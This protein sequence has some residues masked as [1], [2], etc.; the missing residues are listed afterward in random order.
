MTRKLVSIQRIHRID[1]IAK[2]D[3]IECVTIHGW[4]L[5]AKS[6]KCINNDFLLK[7]EQ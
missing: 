4:E 5:V 1:P 2:A 6:F 7:C 3:A